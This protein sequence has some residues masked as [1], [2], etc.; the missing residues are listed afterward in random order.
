VLH[1]LPL[2][3]LHRPQ[4]ESKQSTVS[5]CT[6]HPHPR[7]LLLSSAARLFKSVMVHG[8]YNM[9]VLPAKQEFNPTTTHVLHHLPL[10]VLHRPQWKASNPPS[11]PALGIHTQGC[12]C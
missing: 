12:C 11:L 7:L 2:V 6:W 9:F 5:P 3:V 1:H 8:Q 4:Q 10:V